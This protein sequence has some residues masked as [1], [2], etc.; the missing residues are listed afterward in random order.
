M[1]TFF[2][3]RTVDGLDEL[4]KKMSLCCDIEYNKEIIHIDLLSKILFFSDGEEKKFDKLISTMPLNK[5]L[6]LTGYDKNDCFYTS[7]LVVN[8][9]GIKGANCPK[10][11]WIYFPNSNSGYHRIGIYSNI[12]KNFL[13]KSVIESNKYVSIYV[14]R[15]FSG[16]S[17][18]S[19]EYIEKYKYNVIDELKKINYI[20]SIEAID[21]NWI[22]VAYTWE[23]YDSDWKKNALAFLE[24]NSIYSIGR[25]GG[26]KFQGISDSIREGIVVGGLLRN[27]MANNASIP[28]AR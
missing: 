13:P 7:V 27:K 12:S 8:I 26:W 2:K 1:L 9:G 4:F 10:D 17:D 16:G 23:A 25:F 14:E 15:A 19:N 21:T 18:L 28:T 11:Q 20:D 6:S 3:T 24:K 5:L 22:E